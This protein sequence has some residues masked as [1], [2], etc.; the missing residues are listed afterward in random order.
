ML[1]APASVIDSAA[2]VEPFDV[3]TTRGSLLHRLAPSSRHDR[4]T[5]SLALIGGAYLMAVAA[6][7]LPLFVAAG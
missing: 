7:Y 4:A 1:S 5:P 3:D 6:T 2:M